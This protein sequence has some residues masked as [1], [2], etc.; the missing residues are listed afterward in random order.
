MEAWTWGGL[1]MWFI[2]WLWLLHKWYMS[3]KRLQESMNKM[4]KELI[5]LA[6]LTAALDDLYEEVKRE[7]Q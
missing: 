6:Q 4:E 7:R 2:L 3:A 5:A 1:L